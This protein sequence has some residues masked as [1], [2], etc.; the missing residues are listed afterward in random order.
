MATSPKCISGAIIGLLLLVAGC[1]LA[2]D[3]SA[4]ASVRV[5]GVQAALVNDEPIYLGDLELE[6]AAQGLISPGD[7]FQPDHPDYQ[8]VLDQ[9]IDQRLMAQETVR[10]GLD[11][12][13]DAER[14]LSAARERILSN[15]LVESLVASDVTED[16]IREMYA[17]QVRL[18]QLD[19]EVRISLITVADSE[20]AEEV[21]EAYKDGAEFSA[22][23]FQYSTD[24]TSRVDGGD[25]GFVRPADQAEPFS[26]MIGNTPEGEISDAFESERGWHVLKVNDRRQAAPQTLEE[27]RPEIVTFLTYSEINQILRFLRTNGDIT[28]L[29]PGRPDAGAPDETDAP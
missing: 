15:I 20:T 11:Q 9:L 21:R 26:S 27:M 1:D 13:A 17:E 8:T 24:A 10:R 19:D 22:L 4:A 25:I 2:P 29:E 16:A 28:V 6:A 18:Q 14:R 12:D 23:A 5:E 3:D 7:P